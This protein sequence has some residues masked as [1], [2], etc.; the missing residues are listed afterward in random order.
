MCVSLNELRDSIDI[1]DKQLV[2]LLQKRMRIVSDI[3]VYKKENNLPIYDAN[4]ENE[5]KKRLAEGTLEIKDYYMN[6]LDTIL[7]ESKNY[8]KKINS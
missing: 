5:M 4:R 1:I 7:T 8:Q 6:F 3:A 2:E